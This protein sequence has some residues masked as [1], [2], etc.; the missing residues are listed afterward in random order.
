MCEMDVAEQYEQLSEFIDLLPPGEASAAS[1]DT[2][3]EV[4]GNKALQSFL[5]RRQAKRTDEAEA[6]GQVEELSPP[7]RNEVPTKP[8]RNLRLNCIKGVHTCR[9]DLERY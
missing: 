4:V 9:K 3:L 1:T 7:L 8:L 5:G 6:E 2:K